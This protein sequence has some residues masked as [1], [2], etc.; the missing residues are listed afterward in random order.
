MNEVLKVY[1]NFSSEFFE[2]KLKNEKRYDKLFSNAEK[3]LTEIM[4][5]IYE[6]EFDK[7]SIILI[8]SDHGIGVWRKIR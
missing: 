7:N 4:E 8:M 1:D 2:N 6:L 5:T 3:Y